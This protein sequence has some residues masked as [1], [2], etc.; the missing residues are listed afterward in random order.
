[1]TPVGLN[2]DG[3][4]NVDGLIDDQQFYLHN[5]AVPTPV[6]M[7]ALVDHTYVEAALQVLGPY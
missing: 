3:W 2:P 5:G 1:M 7:H 6:D 4:V